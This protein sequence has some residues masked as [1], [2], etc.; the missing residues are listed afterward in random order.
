M[1]QKKEQAIRIMENKNSHWE[2][3]YRTKS[4]N[5][6]SWYTPHLKTSI[7]LIQEV[8]LDKTKAVIDIGGGASTLLDDLLE[9]GY[10]NL[11]VLDISSTAI[12]ILKKRLK[13]NGSKINWHVGDI[14]T[15]DLPKK[16]FD[17]WH[18][19]AVFHFLTDKESRLK[20]IQLL[21]ISLK[22]NGTFI[23][24]TFGPE[25]PLK[26][27][28]LEIKRYSALELQEELGN[29]FELISSETNS[30]ET[31]FETKQQF[32]YCRFRFL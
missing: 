28:G 18:D 14:T 3:V 20:Y 5:S 6:V 10:N 23:I 25:G 31:P 2:S 1:N 4:A 8:N 11:S 13:N 27:S 32:L 29:A 30:H 9:L 12:A 19:R 16:E 22:K 24:G 21:K 15:Y 26:C 7:R 17:L